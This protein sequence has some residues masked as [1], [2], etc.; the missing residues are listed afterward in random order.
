MRSHSLSRPSRSKK[1]QQ[2]LRLLHQQINQ[3]RQRQTQPLCPHPTRPQTLVVKA[4]GARWRPHSRP[5]RSTR[6]S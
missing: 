3:L 6:T 5:H 2:P 1:P 4:G